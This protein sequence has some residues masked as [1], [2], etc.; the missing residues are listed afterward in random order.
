MPICVIVAPLLPLKSTCYDMYPQILVVLSTDTLYIKLARHIMFLSFPMAQM[1]KNPPV[2]RE[3]SV[4]PLG[5][6]G[7][8]E[9]GMATHSSILAWRISMDREAWWAIVCGVSKSGTQLSD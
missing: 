3:T 1:V 6:K 8:V 4:R 5:L 9:E 2:M 7:P